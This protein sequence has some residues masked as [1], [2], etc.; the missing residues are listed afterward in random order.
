[1]NENKSNVVSADAQAG[2]PGAVGKNRCESSV[3]LE[4]ASEK[5]GCAVGVARRR[6]ATRLEKPVATDSNREVVD[7]VL[8]GFGFERE[9]IERAL[10]QLYISTPTAPVADELLTSRELQAQLKISSTTLWRAGELPHVTIGARRR[11][12]LREVLEHL[13]AKPR[14]NAAGKAKS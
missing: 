6:L 9:Q 7:R 8:A 1:M 2:M 4:I 12:V 11:Y 10:E 13:A 5:N 3:Q 14:R